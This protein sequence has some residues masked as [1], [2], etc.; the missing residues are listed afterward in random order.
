MADGLDRSRYKE[1]YLK[2]VF[3]IEVELVS[4][5]YSI[6]L[7]PAQADGRKVQTSSYCWEERWRRGGG[8]VEE[9]WRRGGG[10]ME[11]RWR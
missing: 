3:M 5:E 7:L 4:I 2:N 1:T 10:D 11:E 8:E 9:R 6:A